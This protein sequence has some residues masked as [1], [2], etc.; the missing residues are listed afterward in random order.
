MTDEEDGKKSVISLRKTV[1]DLQLNPRK[2]EFA[3]V[4]QKLKIAQEG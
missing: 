3:E 2:Q 1:S 4:D